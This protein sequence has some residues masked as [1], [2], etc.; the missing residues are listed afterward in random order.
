MCSWCWGFAPNCRR[1]VAA[2]PHSI[3]VVR[4]LG[5]LAP[6]CD[7]PMPEE[8][9][10]HLRATW[11][12]IEAR[13]PGTRFNYD[14]WSRCRPRRSTWPAC[15]AV[16]AA[17]LQGSDYDL[18]MT[19]AIQRGY[20]LQ[21]KNPSDYAT[22]IEFAEALGLHAGEFAAALN[23]QAVRRKLEQEIA[24]SRQLGVRGFPALLLLNGDAARPVAVNYTDV[25]EMLDR[26]TAMATD[27]AA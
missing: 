24:M 22:L 13:I 10:R 2:L 11:E 21:A 9:R 12:T 19:C 26:I 5:G 1:L 3:T 17:R 20:Y 23:S 7:E 15:R 18:A 25:T 8:M 14:F 16:I 6:D 27:P 4:L